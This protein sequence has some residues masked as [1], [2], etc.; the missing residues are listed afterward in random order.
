MSAA[1]ESTKIER[2][3]NNFRAAVRSFDLL[4]WHQAGNTRQGKFIDM[5]EQLVELDAAWKY[6]KKNYKQYKQDTFENVL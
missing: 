4:L 5:D 3:F 1:R 2:D 6:F